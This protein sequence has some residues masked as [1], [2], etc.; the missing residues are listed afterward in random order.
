MEPVSAAKRGSFAVEDATRRFSPPPSPLA[1][2]KAC[3]LASRPLGDS[4]ARVFSSPTRGSTKT[5]LLESPLGVVGDGFESPVPK[6]RLPTSTLLTDTPTVSTAAPSLSA[7]PLVHSIPLR[8]SP[9]TRRAPVCRGM[10]AGVNGGGRTCSTQDVAT[11][12]PPQR[13][14]CS[15]PRTPK[16]RVRCAVQGTPPAAPKKSAPAPLLEA[17]MNDSLE[18]VREACE[19]DPDAAKLPF[20][21]NNVEPPLCAAARLGCSPSVVELLLQCGADIT[22]RD[23]NNKGP[24]DLLRSQPS[25]QPMAS[26]LLVADILRQARARAEANESEGSVAGSSPPSVTGIFGG[27]MVDGFGLGDIG[28]LWQGVGGLGGT[29]TLPAAGL[30]QPG[31]MGAPPPLPPPTDVAAVLRAAHLWGSAPPSVALTHGGALS[32]VFGR[33][34]VIRYLRG[35]AQL[36]SADHQ[37]LA[38]V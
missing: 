19:R 15:P 20:W 37:R 23:V 8:S 7:T 25:D 32:P 9:H 14:C 29:H 27:T 2:K 3:T 33:D 10:R 16:A 4:H 38:L 13:R 26:T 36:S 30:M 18:A 34:A 21:D 12:P 22:L 28:P 17:L 31:A 5:R 35:Q 6:A 1:A 11:S 24:L